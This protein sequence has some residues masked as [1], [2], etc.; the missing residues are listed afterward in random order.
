MDHLS[1][2]PIKKVLAQSPN[3]LHLAFDKVRLLPHQIAIFRSVLSRWPI[4]GLIADEVG[5]GKT[6]EAGAVMSYAAKFLHVKTIA[7]FVPASLRRQWQS[8]M[9]H[10]FGLEFYIYES[11]SGKLVFYIDGVLIREVSGVSQADY[12]DHGIGHIIFSWHYLRQLGHAGSSLLSQDRPID[13]LVVDEAHAARM[14]QQLNGDLTQTRLYQL[15]SQVSSHIPHKLLLTATPFQTAVQDYSSLLNLFMGENGVEESSMRRISLLNRNL[16][17]QN[18]QKLDAVVEMLNNNSYAI[19]LFPEDLD[20]EDAAVLLALYEEK[21][22]LKHHPST[23]YTVRNT[24]DQLKKIGYEFPD[25][26]ISSTP[27]TLDALQLDLLRLI[28]DYIG[29]NLFSFET[30]IG[31][32]GIGF[33]KTVYNQ[34]IVSS[35]RACY[36]TLNRRI[37]KLRANIRNRRANI[38]ISNATSED[39]LELNDTAADGVILTDAQIAIAETEIRFIDEILVKTRGRIFDAEVMVDPKVEEA[40]RL[41]EDHLALGDRI[42]VFSR[43]TSTTAF[44]VERLMSLDAFSFGRFEGNY[45][46]IIKGANIENVSRNSIAEQFAAGRFPVIVCS[47]AAS[48][49]LNLQSANVL[50]NIDVPWNPARILQRFGRVDRFGQKKASIYFYNLFYPDTIEDTMY[51]RLHRRNQEFRALLGSTPE[52][53]SH[54]HLHSLNLM[55]NEDAEQWSYKNT[56]LNLEPADNI[57]PHQVILQRLSRI[58]DFQI[59]DETITY[60]GNS[61]NYSTDQ[62]NSQYLDLN[63]NLFLAIGADINHLSGLFNAKG[64]MLFLCRS[65]ETK[66]YPLLGLEGILDHCILYRWLQ[67]LLPSDSIELQTLQRDFIDFLN[68]HP[69]QVINH[70]NVSFAN[71]LENSI[72]DGLNCKK[73]D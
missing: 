43:F 51:T 6:I 36:E 34:R 7:L 19:D 55:R 52:I 15:L 39:D 62:M 17:L 69:K 56:L 65:D 23:V 9:Y 29:T 22:Y 54:Q 48:E 72:Y 21:G 71:V 68:R 33:V 66:I 13:M 45:K 61:Y 24:R 70:N 50:I 3:Y 63:H 46:Q 28:S 27:V 47:D 31:T 40:V 38:S 60:N 26:I 53:T 32:K 4:N 11:E 1:N 58:P 35:F 30:A 14:S 20:T 8:E 12:F 41:I 49:G 25:V 37:E 44:L 5:L 42:I 73:I 2:H 64:D 10:L 59:L 18:Q 67:P 16:R 57:R